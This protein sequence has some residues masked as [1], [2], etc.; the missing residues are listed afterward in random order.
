MATLAAGKPTVAAHFAKSS[1]SVRAT[2]DAVVRAARELGPMSEAP[3]KT[4]IHLD[5]STAFA[6]VAT[7]KDALI[8][9]LKA[10]SQV[11]GPRVQKAEKLS[12]N[13]WYFHVRLESPKEVDR[14]LRAWLA[15]S[16][17]IAR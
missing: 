4:S 10:T 3:K 13:R 8:L 2:Y 16:Y 1:P 6:G 11:R 5:R 17:E 12:A 15:D 14:E 9:T 7:R